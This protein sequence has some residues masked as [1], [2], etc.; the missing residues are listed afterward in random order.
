VTSARGAESSPR[1]KCDSKKT[2]GGSA[3]R[4]GNTRTRKLSQVSSRGRSHHG[5]DLGFKKLKKTGQLKERS[6][7]RGCDNIRILLFEGGKK[8]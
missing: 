8:I 2:A 1:K 3:G 5:G 6:H 7:T 4:K